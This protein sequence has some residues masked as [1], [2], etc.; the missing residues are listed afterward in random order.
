MIATRSKADTPSFRVRK[1]TGPVASRPR[2]D[3]DGPGRRRRGPRSHLTSGG[4]ALIL[5]S[6]ITSVLGLPYWVIAARSYSAA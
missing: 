4:L 3:A 6:G 2:N 1:A 5:T